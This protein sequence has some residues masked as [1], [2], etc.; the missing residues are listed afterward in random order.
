MN[1]FVA[2]ADI[3][4]ITS[5][6]LSR[7]GRSDSYCWDFSKSGLYTVKTGY[8]VAHEL[9]STA[10]NPETREPSTI[11]LKS[12]IWKIKAPRKLKHFLWQATAGYM[13]TAK[14][15]NERHCA[16]D[17]ICVRCGADSES[18]NHTLFECPLAL[19]CWEL[20]P[21]PSLPG[22]F[23]CDSLY[24]NMD[25]LLLRAKANGVSSDMLGAFPWIAWYI[26]KARN[27]K[28]FKNKDI[29]PMDTPNSSQGSRKLDVSAESRSGARKRS[30]GTTENKDQCNTDDPLNSMEMPNGCVLDR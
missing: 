4:R 1:E 2:T 14:Q 20:S 11:G 24:A 8:E 22:V 3:P 6:R 28:F 5:L 9:Y 25:F 23:S 30:N 18:I 26:W 21:M 10:N 13:A 15:L 17:S 27:E 16:R 12:V 7:T 19:Q 29:T